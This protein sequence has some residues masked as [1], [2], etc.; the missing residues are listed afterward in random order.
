[1]AKK[2]AL[3][4]SLSKLESQDG[5]TLNKI[6][7]WKK[8]LKLCLKSFLCGDK[9]KQVMSYTRKREIMFIMLKQ[10]NVDYMYIYSM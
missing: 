1:M 7:N 9:A 3:H 2:K 5:N 4:L 8:V 10:N 6:E